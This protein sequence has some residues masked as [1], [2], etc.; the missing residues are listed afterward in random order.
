[1]KPQVIVFTEHGSE[2]LN[3][4]IKEAAKKGQKIQRGSDFLKFSP[5]EGIHAIPAPKPRKTVY[6][7]T[8][9]DAAVPSMVER[10]S[11]EDCIPEGM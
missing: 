9:T 1:M 11:L 4:L 8:E 2:T 7:T 10:Y 3:H 6:G 5:H